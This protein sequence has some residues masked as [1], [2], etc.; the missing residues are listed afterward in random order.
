MK[1]D[2]IGGGRHGS[3]EHLVDANWFEG[4][5]RKRFWEAW[6]TANLGA[7]SPCC[8]IA[9]AEC[10]AG[11]NE[12][13]TTALVGDR[14]WVRIRV[15]QFKA[16]TAVA[17][18]HLESSLLAG[19]GSVVEKRAEAIGGETVGLFE[20]VGMDGDE[21]VAASGENGIGWK[22][23]LNGAAELPTAE[24][25]EPREGIEKFDKLDG[26]TVGTG[27]RVMEDLGNGDAGA[28]GRRA[29]R[30]WLCLVQSD[31][32][33]RSRG[34]SGGK[35]ANQA[36]KNSPETGRERSHA[37]REDTAERGANTQSLA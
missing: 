3:G 25:L 16:Q 34:G 37:V 29:W 12:R 13:M 1:F 32:E 22:R 5:G 26:K 7:G 14:P 6:G 36:P 15:I 31:I 9:F 35:R 27:G 24:I 19:E 11:E 18:P 8:G 20:V 33:S 30:F 23:E 21:E 17:I 28:A 10:G 2:E 4:E